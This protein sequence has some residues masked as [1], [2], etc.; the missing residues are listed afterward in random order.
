MI[1]IDNYK[2]ILEVSGSQTTLVFELMDVIGEM[3]RK[4]PEGETEEY[5]ERIAMAV[6]FQLLTQE[7]KLEV[8]KKEGRR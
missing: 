7:E 5:K 6:E 3:V 2:G 4:A 1:K 8:L